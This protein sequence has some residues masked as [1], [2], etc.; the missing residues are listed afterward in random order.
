MLWPGF[1][2]KRG[3]YVSPFTIHFLFAF[4]EECFFCP[5][6]VVSD[7]SVVV[8][9]ILWVMDRCP[10]GN[11]VYLSVG[12]V[13][14]HLHYA[15]WGVGPWRNACR[16]V[17]VVLAIKDGVMWIHTLGISIDSLWCNAF[18][19]CLLP[20]PSHLFWFCGDTLLRVV[21]YCD[22]EVETCLQSGSGFE[23]IGK[24]KISFVSIT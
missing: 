21:C 14:E 13:P 10:F 24:N 12:M 17:K 5:Y 8:L 4:R 7:L 22:L 3:I 2:F 20:M 1:F 18:W 11:G 23:L 19:V 15:I 9:H 16:W 6:F